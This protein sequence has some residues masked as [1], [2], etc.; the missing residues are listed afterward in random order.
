MDTATLDLDI[1]MLGR[2]RKRGR[3]PRWLA[4]NLGSPRAA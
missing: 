2:L 4:L 1:E 3:K